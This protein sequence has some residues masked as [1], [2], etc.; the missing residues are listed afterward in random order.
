M[1]NGTEHI[2]FEREGK[3]FR[4]ER[5]NDSAD[6]QERQFPIFSPMRNTLEIP[7]GRRPTPETRSHIHSARIKVK[8]QNTMWKELMRQL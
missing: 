1:I 2:F 8:R 3:I 4:S 5:M 6:G 7:S